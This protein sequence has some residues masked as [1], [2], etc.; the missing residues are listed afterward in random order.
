MPP[1][2]ASFMIAGYVVAAVIIVIY[3]VS[4]AV[5]MRKVR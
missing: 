1:D 4:L 3:A 5:R 2:N